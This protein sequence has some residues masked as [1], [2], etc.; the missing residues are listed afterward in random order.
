MSCLR[1][2]AFF[3]RAKSRQKTY[4]R[5]SA[6]EHPIDI[7]IVIDKNMLNAITKKLGEIGYTHVG[8]LG[9]EGREAFNYENKPHLMEHHLY[10]CDKDA[11][12][13]KRHI[14]LREFLRENQEYRDKYSQIKIEMAQKYPHDIDNYI[15]GKQPIILEIYQKCGLDTSY[16][17]LL[18][19]PT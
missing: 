2:P 11:D 13:L 9:I 4:S 7:D 16:K 15:D 6:L 5:A 1:R 14:V 18:S 12:E 3:R 17:K 8:D 19:K 10:V